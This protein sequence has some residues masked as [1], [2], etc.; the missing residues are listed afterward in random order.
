MQSP[1]P[2]QGCGVFTITHREIVMAQEH[3]RSNREVKKPKAAKPAKEPAPSLMAA[4][5]LTPIKAP[6]KTH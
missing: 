3:K 2:D 5:R 6:K 1:A 4:G